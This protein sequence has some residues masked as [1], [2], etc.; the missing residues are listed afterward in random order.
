[1][2]RK[3]AAAGVLA[4]IEAGAA[5]EI[6]KRMEPLARCAAVEC[7]RDT[8]I[9]AGLFGAEDDPDIWPPPETFDRI[10]WDNFE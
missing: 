5:T 1:M 10:N 6:A 2:V 9:A 8:L 4:A 7:G 3:V